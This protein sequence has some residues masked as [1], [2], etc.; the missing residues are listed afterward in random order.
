MVSGQYLL[1]I[2]THKLQTKCF[3]FRDYL[4]NH[5]CETMNNDQFQILQFILLHKTFYNHNTSFRD[6][7]YSTSTELSKKYWEI[8]NDGKSPNVSWQILKTVGK[9]KNGQRTC[10]LCLTEKLFIIK[11]RDKHLLNSRS[12]IS[13][14]CRHKRKFLLSKV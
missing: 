9:Y 5:Q 8:K 10:N 7:K 6:V 13:S 11:C 2:E 14:K 3:M 1:Q 12:E 4:N